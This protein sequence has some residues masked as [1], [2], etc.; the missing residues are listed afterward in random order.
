MKELIVTIGLVIL[1]CVI[2]G[3]VIGTDTDKGIKGAVVEQFV[4]EVEYLSD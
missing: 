1:G 4:D 2:F 3:M